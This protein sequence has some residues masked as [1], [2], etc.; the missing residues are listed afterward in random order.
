MNLLMLLSIA[1]KVLGSALPLVSGLWAV[2]SRTAQ[3]EK[4]RRFR[5][6]VI[7]GLFAGVLCNAAAAVLD[8]ETKNEA[9]AKNAFEMTELH[10]AAVASRFPTADATVSVTLSIDKE[11]RGLKRL[12]NRLER[13][14]DYA[15]KHCRQAGDV[16]PCK[17]YLIRAVVI[18]ELRFDKK[19]L[20]FP[21]RK[22]D[23]LSYGIL[24]GVGVVVRFYKEKFQTALL[25]PDH[26]LDH[27][28]IGGIIVTPEAI[29][30]QTLIEW[31][32]Y[33]LR[34]FFDAKLPSDAFKTAGVLSIA[35]VLGRG[36]TVRPWARG[37]TVCPKES[38]EHDCD[39]YLVDL[40]KAVKIETVDI[41]FPHRKN[42]LLWGKGVEKSK[43]NFD[44]PY[45]FG[46]FPTDVAEFP[47]GAAFPEE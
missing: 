5:W 13:E 16:A 6:Y 4:L 19:S 29:P 33:R 34:L 30:G 42:F 36:F 3:E 41:R 43:D 26:G 28:A 35:D 9:D 1:L 27:G 17:D 25:G 22:D 12:R 44:I 10:L 18:D 37:V 47:A 38:F 21:S 31:D 8:T 11:F 24:T 32:G 7:S 45:L 39:E 15:R 2:F 40:L 23:Q 46:N 14:L 20:L